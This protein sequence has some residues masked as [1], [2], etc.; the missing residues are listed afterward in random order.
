MSLVTNYSIFKAVDDEAPFMGSST[1]VTIVVY[2]FVFVIGL[3]G[4]TLAIYVVLRYAKMKTVTNIYIL[5]LALADELYILGL[6]FLTTHNVLSYWPFGEFLC[7][8]FMTADTMNQFTSTFCLTV[9]SIDRYLAVVHPIRSAKWRR[10]RVA[11]VVNGVVWVVSLLVVLPVT[12][13]SDVQDGF[14]SCNMSW[15]EPKD[16]WSTAFILYTVILG[17]FVPLL[18]ICLCYLLIIIKVRTAGARAGLTKRRRSERMVTRMVVII[19]LVFVLCWL[20]FYITNMVNQVFIIPENSLMAGIYFFLVIL[21]YVNSC[22]NPF[23]YGLL[24]ENF[25]QSFQ[26][27][28]CLHKANGVGALEPV[29]GRTMRSEKAEVTQDPLF[30]AREM[31]SNGHVQNHQCVQIVSQGN[32]KTELLPTGMPVIDQS[33]L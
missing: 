18:I 32:V 31:N 25:K 9:M 7:R 6:P 4:N 11:K 12:I 17:F 27:V 28:L 14:N 24:S 26:K 16:F 3:L 22:A 2:I 13:Y 23:L 10:P 1:V 21:T 29:G 15:P 8:V 30:T 33:S 20:P 19:V 5:N